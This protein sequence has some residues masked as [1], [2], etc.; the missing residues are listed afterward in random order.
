M[1]LHDVN[2]GVTGRRKRRRIGR[3]TG[4]GTGKT[5]GR[6]HKGHKA[7]S[8]YWR[9]SIFQGGMMPLVRR[10]P[11]RG[12]NNKFALIVASVN[13]GALDRAF[14]A[15]EEVTPETLAARGVVK[16][17]YDVLKILGDGRLTKKLR[18]SAHRFSSSAREKITSAGGTVTE[19]PGKAPVHPEKVKRSKP[20]GSQESV[21]DT[22]AAEDQES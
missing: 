13:V 15:G 5:S 17:R 7:T 9:K 2:N 12:F 18:V 3:G 14:E 4:S 19:L 1:N 6:G 10:V 21:G 16:G 20:A 11:K 22:P 8:G